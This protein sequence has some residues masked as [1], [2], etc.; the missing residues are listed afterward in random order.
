[1]RKTWLTACSLLAFSAFGAQAADPPKWMQQTFPED[2]LAQG[3]QEYQSVY[4]DDAL[5]GK[6]KHLIALGV[7]AQI[8]CDYCVLGHTQAAKA[9]GAT[10]EAIK[11]AIAA[12]ALVRKWSTVLNG[13]AYDM[14]AFRTEMTGGGSAGN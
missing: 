4:A 11:E 9:A 7:A 8:P 12:A 2:A 14:Q 13:A 5:S 1:M 6:D 10:E 3:W